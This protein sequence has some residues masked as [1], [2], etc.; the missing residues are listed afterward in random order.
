MVDGAEA[1]DFMIMHRGGRNRF[2]LYIQD[3]LPQA[4]IG[5]YR[6]RLGTSFKC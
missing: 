5:C 1:R 2:V 4:I 3:K 6:P